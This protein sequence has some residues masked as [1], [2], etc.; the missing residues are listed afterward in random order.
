MY[1]IRAEKLETDFRDFCNA[2]DSTLVEA[3]KCINLSPA[4]FLRWRSKAENGGQVSVRPTVLDKICTLIDSDPTNYI[5]GETKFSGGSKS[6]HKSS[7]K[8]LKNGTRVT[9]Y[10]KPKDEVKEPKAS[11]VD[12]MHSAARSFS[13]HMEIY[14]RLLGVSRDYMNEIYEGYSEIES[15]ESSLSISTYMDISRAFISVYKQMEDGPVKNA[16]EM[17]AKEYNDI[18]VGVVYFRDVRK[19]K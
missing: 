3:F 9:V 5:L 18:F 7:S 16:F 8:R 6:N 10:S 12:S 19:V 13:G 11:S 4:T 17:I 14:R 2:T 15:G 1:I